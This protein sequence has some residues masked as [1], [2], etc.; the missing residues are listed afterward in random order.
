MAILI[1]LSMYGQIAKPTVYIV[2]SEECPICIYMSK[3]L[4]E[5]HQQYKD[6]V[7]FKLVFPQSL[8]N[9]KTMQLFKHKYSLEGFTSILDEDQSL[10]KKLGAT[11]T[12]EAIIE[13][14]DGQI[15]YRGRINDAYYAPGRL[16]RVSNQNDLTEAIESVL[17]DKP[18]PVP[19][20]KAVGCY[21]TYLK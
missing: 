20:P 1:Q 5:L 16:R 11:I 10:S 14:K 21:I 13:N 17:N 15:V 9:Y 6:K 4:V 3:P 12:P 7:N 8:S 2:V 18:V 19:W